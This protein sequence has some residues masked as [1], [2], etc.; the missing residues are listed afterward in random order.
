MHLKIDF[1]NPAHLKLLLLSYGVN[2][3]ESDLHDVG[4]KYS[5]NRYYYG[6]SNKT[7]EFKNNLPSGILLPDKI[8][9]NIYFNPD[10]D[11][12]IRS[13]GKEIGLFWKDDFITKIEFHHRPK[14]FDKKIDQNIDCKQV[15]S[16]YCRHVLGIFSNGFCYF[17]NSKEQ[18]KFCSLLPSRNLL[19][20]QNLLVLT[21][22]I[23][24]EAVKIALLTDSSKIKYIQYTCGTHKNE[25]QS[26]LEQSHIINAV[27]Q[28]FNKPR[29]HYLTIMPT[30]KENLYINLKDSGLD[31]ISFGME[32]FDK[33]LF[34]V[35]C[36]GKT[37]Y[38]G[39]DNFLGSFEIARKIFG[40]SNVYAGF[41]GGLEPLESLE[42]GMNFFGEKGISI[43]VN[44]FHPDI[45]T[46]LWNR[47]R[48]T[49]DY[50]FQMAKMQSKIYKKYKLKPL[51]PAGGRRSS[52]DTEVYRGFFE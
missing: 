14:F 30:I 17:F 10:S 31:V 41:V 19:G 26:Y 6:I 1:K 38:F 39:Y 24:K 42:M 16:M 8:E 43:A 27:K 48:P 40:H 50:L 35:Y 22:E 18:C 23:V 45:N 33:D 13:N 4:R 46:E 29:A 25:D 51:F 52:L 3:K 21:P 12:S 44:A 15:I 37:K 11:L 9:S 47:P 2:F 49:V 36:P 20:N 7:T 28:L 5:E 32:I 34:K